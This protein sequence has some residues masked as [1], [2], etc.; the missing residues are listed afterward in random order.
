MK[1][2]DVGVLRVP[3]NLSRDPRRRSAFVS[4]A[5]VFDLPDEGVVCA[6]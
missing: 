1:A 6:R 4:V 3:Y 2:N 5:A